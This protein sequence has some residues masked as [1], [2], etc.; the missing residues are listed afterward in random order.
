MKSLKIAKGGNQNSYIEK[1]QKHNGQ[2]REYKRT[3]NDT[4]YKTY[5]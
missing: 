4:I 2:K 5:T 3:N 1:E